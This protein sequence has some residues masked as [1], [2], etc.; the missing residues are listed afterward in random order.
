MKISRG[1]SKLTMILN[2]SMSRFQV[3]VAILL[4]HR[5]TQI[6]SKVT[7]FSPKERLD[8]FLK[9]QRLS[10]VLMNTFMQNHVKKIEKIIAL[11]YPYLLPSM[12]ILFVTNLKKIK[13]I[14]YC[15]INL[16]ELK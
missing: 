2:K 9:M 7:G 3:K 4:L 11:I 13:S 1:R 5:M 15:V 10:P 8:L 16:F 6:K 14:K 12:N